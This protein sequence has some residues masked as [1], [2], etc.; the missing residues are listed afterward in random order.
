MTADPYT[1][2]ATGVLI[3]KL[4][5]TTTTELHQAERDLTGLAILRLDAQPTH[6]TY[7]LVHLR[8]IH[9]V[10]FGDI[11]PWAGEIRTVGIAKGDPF[12]LPQHIESSAKAVFAELREENHLSDLKHEEF[13]DRFTHYFGE[14]NALHPFREGNGRTQRVFFGQLARDAG[15][16][17]AWRHLDADRNIEASVAIMRG[18]TKPMRTML[19]QLISEA[20]NLP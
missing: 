1:D 15:F 18:D 9:K 20:G 19:D 11:Y 16:A 5:L 2:P 4:G 14:V 12:C 3:N 6:R 10:L 8:S 17:V 13:V 7:D